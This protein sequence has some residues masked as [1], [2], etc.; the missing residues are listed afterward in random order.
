MYTLRRILSAEVGH[1]YVGP[2]RHG[3]LVVSVNFFM[4]D[5]DDIVMWICPFL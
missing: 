4:S 3:E 5:L 1:L 2:G